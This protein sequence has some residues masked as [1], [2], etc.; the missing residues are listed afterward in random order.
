MEENNT[1]KLTLWKALWKPWTIIPD[2]KLIFFVWF[3]FTILASQIGTII[4]LII[5]VINGELSFIQS[6]YQESV[7]GS[8]YTFSIVLIASLLSPLF[9]NFVE[10]SPTHFK[11][12]KIVLITILIF[13]LFFAGIFY[14]TSVKDNYNIEHLSEI[15][16]SVDIYQ[17]IF[18]IIAIILALYAF[19]VNRLD[20]NKE[21]YE[22][23]NDNDYREKDDKAR[24][25]L[26]NGIENIITDNKGNNI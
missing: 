5:R 22:E 11:S 13:T 16:Y 19:C 3:M 24:D 10:N 25:A 12:I 9:I 14:S 26:S 18:F 17:L 4:N 20:L 6:I 2:N 15:L 8:F 21:K 1:K 23:L 7:N